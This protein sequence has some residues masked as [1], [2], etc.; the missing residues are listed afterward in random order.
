ME[1]SVNDNKDNGQDEA[2]ARTFHALF[3]VLSFF[4]ILC[5]LAL[6]GVMISRVKAEE[7]AAQADEI[8][9]VSRDENSGGAEV[10]P[11]PQMFPLPDTIGSPGGGMIENSGGGDLGAAVVDMNKVDEGLKDDLRL[12][13]L[14]HQ[15]QEGGQEKE[16]S[17][18]A[19][20]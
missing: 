10:E 6:A 12:P 16:F 11:M 7:D 2:E 8:F 14:D 9:V 15:A 5:G 18:A 20:E 1:R 4:L 19:E 17:P 3:M 13:L